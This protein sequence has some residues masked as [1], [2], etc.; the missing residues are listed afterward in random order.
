[1]IFLH[2]ISPDA[3]HRLPETKIGDTSFHMRVGELSPAFKVVNR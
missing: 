2:D 3:M 1:M